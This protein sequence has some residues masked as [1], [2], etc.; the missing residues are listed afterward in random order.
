MCQSLGKIFQSSKSSPLHHYPSSSFRR[1]ACYA[2]RNSVTVWCT[3]SQSKHTR[4]HGVKELCVITFFLI[5]VGTREKKK[6]NRTQI[7]ANSCSAASVFRY[8]P[9]E[10][11]CPWRLQKE[12]V[13][14]L[15]QAESLVPSCDVRHLL[16]LVPEGHVS[17]GVG[18]Q[19]RKLHRVDSE[20]T[21]SCWKTR[22]LNAL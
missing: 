1:A 16:P 2:V 7:Y 14:S 6:L 15:P 22:L 3:R 5:V 19:I 21:D 20:T 4:W 10:H 13:L 8:V 17:W 18:R 11:Q 12:D 9:G